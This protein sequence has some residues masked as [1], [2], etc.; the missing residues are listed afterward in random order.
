MNEAT[1]YQVPQ[2]LLQAI[3][4]NLNSQPAANT[5]PLLNAI[6]AECAKQDQARDQ[7][8]R[9][10]QRQ[11]IEAELKEKLQAAAAPVQ[12]PAPPPPTQT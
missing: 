1:T 4:D 10:E 7:L 11:A 5:R 12:A 9:D 6:E 3:V 2:V 8:A